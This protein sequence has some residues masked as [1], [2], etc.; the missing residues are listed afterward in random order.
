MRK[1]LAPILLDDDDS[2]TPQ[3]WRTLVV[4]P[5]QRSL[6]AQAKAHLK[7]TEEEWSVHS[8]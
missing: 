4:Q 1:G 5:A 2:E 6:S 8:F 7:R 3:A